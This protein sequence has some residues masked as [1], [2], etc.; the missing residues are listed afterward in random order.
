MNAA[1]LVSMHH[2]RA[3]GAALI[4]AIVGAVALGTAT[5]ATASE[6]PANRGWSTTESNR[7]WSADASANR[8]WSAPESLSYTGSA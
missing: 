7:G 6:H 3:L 1:K 2:K 5:V 4:A 8:G